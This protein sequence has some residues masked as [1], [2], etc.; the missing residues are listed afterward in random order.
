MPAPWLSGPEGASPAPLDADSA[1]LA[2]KRVAMADWIAHAAGQL[3]EHGLALYLDIVMDRC[4]IGAVADTAGPG[5]YQP[6]AENPA[7]D[8]RMSIDVREALHLR[9][10]PPPPGFVQAW[11]TRLKRWTERGAAGYVFHAPQCLPAQDWAALAAA[12][13]GPDRR[14]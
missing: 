13:G 14:D 2:G 12:V 4:A 9:P 7:R 1:L 10:G 8:P 5:W 11:S 6:P 3:A